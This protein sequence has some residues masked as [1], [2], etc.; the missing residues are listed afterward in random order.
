MVLECI[1]Q[2]KVNVKEAWSLQTGH[3]WECVI[4]KV[5]FHRNHS[6]LSVLSLIPTY[7]YAILLRSTNC[8]R[9]FPKY[10]SSWKERPNKGHLYSLQVQLLNASQGY[11]A[12]CGRVHRHQGDTA[13]L[14]KHTVFG[15]ETFWNFLKVEVNSSLLSPPPPVRKYSA[16]RIS[17]V[18]F[19]CSICGVHVLCTLN[20][21][22][23][24][25]FLNERRWNGI[26]WLCAIP[27]V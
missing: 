19:T 8:L 6:V 21:L 13:A 9:S 16:Q 25:C 24:F 10:F 11:G 2:R 14:R 12:C 22:N 15:L 23:Q 20:W 4:F 1:F 27:F 7:L 17:L 5:K 3:F 26:E 18:F